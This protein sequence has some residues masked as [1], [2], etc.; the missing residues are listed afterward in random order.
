MIIPSEFA[1]QKLDK[2]ELKLRALFRDIDT[3]PRT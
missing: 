3:E 1:F 2:V